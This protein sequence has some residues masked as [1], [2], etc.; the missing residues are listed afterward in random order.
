MAGIDPFWYGPGPTADQKQDDD[1]GNP[2]PRDILLFR[3]NEAYGDFALSRAV[4]LNQNY[5]LPSTEDES[6]MFRQQG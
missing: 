4:K 1:V 3:R 5:T 2:R 6:A